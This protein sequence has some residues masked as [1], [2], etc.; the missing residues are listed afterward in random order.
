MKRWMR[1]RTKV[2]TLQ[3]AKDLGIRHAT[4]CVLANRQIKTKKEAMRFLYGSAQLPSI[5]E[6]YRMKDMKHGVLLLLEAIRQKKNIVV[7]GDYD[8]DGVMSSV[9]LCKSILRCG[10]IV[11]S[12]VPHRQKEGY[13]LNKEAV[14]RLTAEQTQVLLT[15]DN[16]IAA[17]REI[18]LAKEKGMTVIVL[19]HHEPAFIQEG[20]ERKELLPQADALIDPKQAACAYPF[21]SLCAAGISFRFACCLLQEAGKEDEAFQNELLTFAS[22]ATVCDIVDLLDENRDL[23]K[24]GLEYLPNTKQTGLR[25]L[26]EETGLQGRELTEY[27]LGFV[28]GPCVNATG[29]LES[30][31]TAV[32]LF[33]TEDSQKAR[34]CAKLLVELNAERKQ[35]TIQATQ[36]ALLKAKEEPYASDPVLVLYDPLVQESVAGIAAGRVKDQLHRPVLMITKSENGAKGSARSIEAYHMFEALL[37]C[38]ELFTKFGGHAMAAGFSLPEENI[39]PLRE[40][41]LASCKLTAEDLTAVL[42]IEKELEFSEIDL[43]LAKELKGLSPFGKGNPAPLFGTKAVYMDRFS[44]IGKNRDILRVTL[45]EEKSGLRLNAISFDGKETFLALLEEGFPKIWHEDI[46]EC[47]LISK[48]MDFVYSV[49]INTYNGRSSVQ[50]VLKD[51]RWT[52]E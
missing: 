17:L 47:G 18:E 5:E 26:I 49:D 42:R 46:M 12:Y 15:C 37:E 48:P 29:R 44:W 10:G 52:K 39:A 45:R 14:E 13:G 11:K 51:F 32:E 19:D 31:A 7:Y 24:K 36:N 16:G 22:I 40:K 20:T 28:I 43:L 2:D 27:H 34:S 38:K 23:V 50:L 6:V 33:M 21:K 30:A 25:A 3:M 9:I 35:M 4:A 8:V 41:L 1:K